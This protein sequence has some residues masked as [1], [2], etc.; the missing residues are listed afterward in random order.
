MT[1]SELARQEELKSAVMTAFREYE[2]PLGALMPRTGMQPTAF[3]GFAMQTVMQS[4]PLL[5]ATANDPQSLMTALMKCAMLGHIPGSK[6]AALVPFGGHVE[7]I[8]QYHGIVDRAQ[9]AC[10]GLVMGC[11]V[12]R[13]GDT[14]VVPEHLGDGVRHT[15]PSPFATAKDRGPRIGSWAQAKMPARYG[16]DYTQAAMLNIEE[17][18]KISELSRKEKYGQYK[19]R[20]RFWVEHWDSMAKKAAIKRIPGL[21]QSAEYIERMGMLHVDAE[22]VARSVGVQVPSL[23]YDASDEVVHAEAVVEPD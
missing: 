17:L 13:Q 9:R 15:L 16:G 8:E 19:G 21:P 10:P 11:G 2:Q 18:E 5:Q 3:M 6:N 20:N 14:F 4:E 22:Q 12:V 1:G 23:E 7:L